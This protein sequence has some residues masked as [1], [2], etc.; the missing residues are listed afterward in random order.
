VV[1]QDGA[2]QLREYLNLKSAGG[3]PP[4]SSFTKDANDMNDTPSHTEDYGIAERFAPRKNVLP[5]VG[6]PSV[7]AMRAIE[8]AING[9]SSI[10][11]TLAARNAVHGDFTDDAG[12]AQAFKDVMRATKNWDVLTPVQREALEHIATK[13][14]RI[15]SGNPEH[16]DHWEDIQGYARLVEDRL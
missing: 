10:D 14:G 13:I 12:T 4:V 1:H 3:S 7:E 6:L 16:R 11:D 5:N 9:P 8:Q 15:L 2:A